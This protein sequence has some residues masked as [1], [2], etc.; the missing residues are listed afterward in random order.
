MYFSY[1]CDAEEFILRSKNLDNNEYR[2]KYNKPIE[3]IFNDFKLK[4]NIKWYNILDET[5]KN[6]WLH[7]ANS[8]RPMILSKKEYENYMKTHEYVENIGWCSNLKLL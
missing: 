6:K 7:Y 1:N 5:M 8:F 2:V 4:Y 3:K